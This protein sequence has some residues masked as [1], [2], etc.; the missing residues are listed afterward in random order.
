M[1][2]KLSKPHFY[3]L[4]FFNPREKVRK[5]RKTLGQICPIVV[6]HFMSFSPQ[7]ETND[8]LQ[9]SSDMF[10]HMV[11]YIFLRENCQNYISKHN[12]LP[13]PGRLF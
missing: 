6:L 9:C 10:P 8:A 3:V 11:M 4:F 5:A 2:G 1:R 12:C 7:L 13:I